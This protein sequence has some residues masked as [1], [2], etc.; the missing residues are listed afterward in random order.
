MPERPQN[1]ILLSFF[2]FF[3]LHQPQ[4]LAQNGAVPDFTG[5]LDKGLTLSLMAV[6]D[7][8]LAKVRKDPDDRSL[9]DYYENLSQTDHIPQLKKW[10][11][12]NPDSYIPWTILGRA[13][14]RKGWEYRGTTVASKVPKDMWKLFDACLEEA[15]SYLDK[16]EAMKADDPYPYDYLMIIGRAKCRAKYVMKAYLEEALQACPDNA[17][18]EFTMARYYSPM[19]CGSA[20]DMRAF[21]DQYGKTAPEG[22]RARLLVGAYYDEILKTKNGSVAYMRQPRVW[23]EISPEFETYLSHHPQDL[24]ERVWYSFWAY[25]SG[26]YEVAKKQFD[27]LGGHWQ[28]ENGYWSE[29][30]FQEAKEKTVK[31]LDQTP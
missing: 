21:V 11:Q 9:Y 10:A 3:L 31:A 17:D 16:A 5:D 6:H 4:A 19:W 2:L 8:L 15:K 27:L 25:Y 13:L 30:S 28:F 14:I 12:H 20:E 23:D 22:S 29:K 7:N 26:H 1:P 24:P 18:A